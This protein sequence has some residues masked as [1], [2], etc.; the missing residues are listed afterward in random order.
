MPAPTSLQRAA[1][2][3]LFV[4]LALASPLH[5]HDGPHEPEA[6]A[7]A[8]VNLFTGQMLATLRELQRASP[9]ERVKLERQLLSQ[10]EKRQASL[11]SIVKRRPEKVV[12]NALPAELRAK[13]PASI[14]AAIEQEVDATGEVVGRVSDDFA[15]ANSRHDFFLE[16]RTN[17]GTT[18]VNLDSGDSTLTNDE[19]RKLVGAQVRI[20]GVLLRDHLVVGDRR[21]LTVLAARGRHGSGGS[22][23]QTSA[24]GGGSTGASSGS[25]GTALA[26]PVNETTLV[27]MG[28]FT[29][30][31]FSCSGG[32]AQLATNMFSTSTSVASLNRLY[33]E[34]SRQLVSFSGQVVGPFDIN[35]SSG[36]SC[37]YT[38]WGNALKAA[39]QA[40]GINLGSYRR[41]SYAIPSVGSCGWSGLAYL[42]GSFPTQSWVASCNTGVFVHEIGHN[43]LFH[44]AA[45]PTSEYGDGSDP[46]G[47]AKMVQF[48]ASNR[49]AAGWQPAATVVDA[50]S[51]GSYSIT[52]VSM[53]TSSAPQILR[54][55]KSDTNEYYYVSMRT[56]AGFDANLASSYKNAVSVHRSNGALLSKT[57]I[58]AQLQPGQTFTD[59]ANGI[60]ITPQTISADA[61]TISVGGSAPVCAPSAPTVALSPASQSGAP[62]ESRQ[63]TMTVTNRNS[64]A[65]ASSTFSLAQTLPSGFTGAFSPAS[66][67]I[68]PGASA[69][70][71]WSVTPA[72]GTSDASYTIT[73]R[74]TDSASGGGTAEASG[75]YVVFSDASAPLVTL[76]SPSQGAILKRGRITLRA[77]ASDP[78]GISRVEFYVNGQL[79]AKDT[80]AP[81]SVS[82]NARSAA[83]G[84]WTITARAYDRA[85]N[86]S[87]STVSVTM[88]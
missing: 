52:S 73:G 57:Y 20:R 87:D 39:A 82:W 86:R 81:Y 88:Q 77:N 56:G 27:I 47:G 28:N 83:L 2:A 60:T 25:G 75:A 15:N 23:V 22:S 37:D 62:G 70:A 41:V 64:P 85:N 36:G 40:A 66:V 58:L 9:G 13:L 35:Y 29:D 14:A 44:H 3:A 31:A 11:Y 18:R 1:L 72:S 79:L 12:L 24:A 50:S 19:M 6:A 71:S 54:I 63:Y 7:E 55:R 69:N 49:V 74:A 4:S 16:M 34:T 33:Q 65:C 8:N 61:A 17:G 48:N 80:R 30:K 59:S 42:G 45:T 10:I 46:M 68:A 53:T 5:A 51:S 32:A 21:G 43:M 26:A 38:G 78:D 84:E 67:A 76:T